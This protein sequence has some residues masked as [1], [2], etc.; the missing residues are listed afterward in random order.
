LPAAELEQPMILDDHSLSRSGSS[1][2]PVVWPEVSPEN[3]VIAEWDWD[4]AYMGVYLRLE[5]CNRSPYLVRAAEIR[6]DGCGQT[7]QRVVTSRQIKVG[8]LFPGVYVH[9]E[10]GIGAR[11]GISGLSF[12]SVM[13]RAVRLTPP[14]GMVPAAEYPM[15]AAEIIDVTNEEAPDLRGAVGDASG[16]P[17]MAVATTVHIRVR[18]AGPAVVER[19]RL[20]LHYFE[21][22]GEETGAR[23]GLQRD[24][25]AAWIFDMPRKE[26]NPYR[27]PPAPEAACDPADPLPPG[28]AYEF[29]LVHYDR[30]P[31]G[32]AGCPEAVSVEVCALKLRA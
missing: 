9:E 22:E 12:N 27:L 10:I 14:A 1:E 26:W 23:T 21:A 3:I 4:L 19:V 18:N 8:P 13:A 28:Q 32:W 29:M 16:A 5:I 25:V 24:P 15:L 17:H 7:V 11:E 30:G 31:H 6:I 20:K 2:I